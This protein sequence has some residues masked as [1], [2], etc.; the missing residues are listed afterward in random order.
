M[1]H[2]HVKNLINLGFLVDE[3]IAEK[4][5][6]LDEESFY[7]VIEF[8]KK[9]KPFMLT[10]DVLDK[11][12]T[13]DIEVLE[14]F[15]PVS[16]FT[17]HDYVKTLNERYKFLHD[18]LINKVELKNIVSINKAGNGDVSIIG[19]VKEMREKNSRMLVVLEDPTGDIEALADKKM[20]EKL[21]LD[22]VVAVSGKINNKILFVDKLLFPGIPL[23][24]VNYS[25]ESVKIAFL[26]S[27]KSNNIEYVFYKDKIKDR[28]KKKT[29]EINEPC[30]VKVK[31]VIILV[32]FGFDPLT[33]INKRYVRKDNTDFLI[34][35]IPDILFTDSKK[36]MSYKGVS[37]VSMDNTIDLKT[38]ELENIV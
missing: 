12:L 29:Y 24:P 22:D 31:N 23:R 8:L 5:E 25:E 18:I 4:V 34:D 37:I 32:I 2:S 13:K 15:K 17:I 26:S 11:I 7:K 1:N 6:K 30:F 10:K 9:E 16:S 36:N 21:S 38:R 27:K 35:K 28:I 33:I 20:V 19:L 3:Q 14:Q